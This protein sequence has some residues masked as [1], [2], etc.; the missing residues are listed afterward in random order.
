MQVKVVQ[1]VVC[2]VGPGYIDIPLAT[3]FPRYLRVIGFDIDKNRVKE[4]NHHNVN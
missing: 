1:P 2:V 3:A 4:L